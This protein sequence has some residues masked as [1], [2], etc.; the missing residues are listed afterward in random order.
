MWGQLQMRDLRCF[1]PSWLGPE[2][3]R[4]ET[5]GE[6]GSCT[7]LT[8][9]RGTGCPPASQQLGAP[10][11]NIL[12]TELPTGGKGVSAEKDCRRVIV[13]SRWECKTDQAIHKTVTTGT[14]FDGPSQGALQRIHQAPHRR[15]LQSHPANVK[16]TQDF[17]SCLDALVFPDVPFSMSKLGT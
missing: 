2:A 9:N 11:W 13:Y 1:G 12:P 16:V 15:R 4:R 3:E 5:A 7:P 14:P 10:S 17:S 6:G 8:V